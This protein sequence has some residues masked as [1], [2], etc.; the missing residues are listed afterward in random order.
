M[1]TLVL[2]AT[3]ALARAEADHGSDPRCTLAVAAKVLARHDSTRRA[4]VLDR[5]QGHGLLEV[6]FVDAMNPKRQRSS[7]RW[8]ATV[9]DL[10]EGRLRN[11]ALKKLSIW[12]GRQELFR[13]AALEPGPTLLFEEDAQ[14][15]PGF[16]PRVSHLLD[17]SARGLVRWGDVAWLG[18]CSSGDR[19]RDLAMQTLRGKPE[20]GISPL[21]L[22][23]A[24][25]P[26]AI[27][28]PTALLVTPRGAAAARN[29]LKKWPSEYVRGAFAACGVSVHTMA[30]TRPLRAGRD[31]WLAIRYGPDVALGGLF[32]SRQLEG[33]LVEPA[34]AWQRWQ[35]RPTAPG[36]RVQS[37]R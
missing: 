30:G 1:V 23:N 31:C 17:A 33:V 37:R 34:L 8:R 11:L 29:L 5:L 4:E 25:S 3:A 16:C 35:E 14:L 24:S 7:H 21:R 27:H 2:L 19:D 12:L 10:P 28:C 15:V 13:R 6:H 32:R 22:V 36:G 26:T 18:S 9:M 20:A